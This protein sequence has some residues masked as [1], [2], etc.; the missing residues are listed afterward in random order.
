MKTTIDL[1]TAADAIA[2]LIEIGF[3]INVD[4]NDRKNITVLDPQEGLTVNLVFEPGHKRHVTITRLPAKLYST[5][6][7][8]EDTPASLAPELPVVQS[9]ELEPKPV[10]RRH[11]MP[12]PEELE[13]KSVKSN[14]YVRY[15]IEKNLARITI[16]SLL[17]DD[18]LLK[19]VQSTHFAQR[20]SEIFGYKLSTARR[21]VSRA[22]KMGI[23]KRAH[24]AGD[25][26]IELIT[27][28]PERKQSPEELPIPFSNYYLEE[29]KPALEMAIDKAVDETVLP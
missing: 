24:F 11:A 16:A 1:F 10:K 15:N 23:L 6:R 17:N 18:A 8:L 27:N 12:S 14:W 2:D 4:G 7:T 22:V 19:R 21:H 20:M 29:G 28:K 26:W 5:H 9:V 13:N 3:V 25:Y